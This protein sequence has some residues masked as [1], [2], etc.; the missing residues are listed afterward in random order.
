MWADNVT[1]RWFGGCGSCFRSCLLTGLLAGAPTAVII[2]S[3]VKM[4]WCGGG[5]KCVVVLPPQ[6][7]ARFPSFCDVT[8]RNAM[9]EFFT[10][11]KSVA[12]LFLMF[13]LLFLPHWLW[14]FYLL[15]FTVSLL[16]IRLPCFNKLELRLLFWRSP[17]HPTLSASIR[18]AK[19]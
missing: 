7:H 2:R 8:R 16:A 5:G 10:Q 19:Y 6:P 1:A 11:Q 3:D 15:L 13:V 4:R 17:S 18:P 12:L 9:Q 14:S